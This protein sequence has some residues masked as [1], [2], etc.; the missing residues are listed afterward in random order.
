MESFGVDFLVGGPSRPS[1]GYH[2]HRIN[3]E[4]SASCET[5]MALSTR[6]APTG[7]NRT[8]GWARSRRSMDVPGDLRANYA[9][10]ST[11]DDGEEAPGRSYQDAFIRKA[12]WVARVGPRVALSAIRDETPRHLER[13]WSTSRRT[14][15]PFSGSEVFPLFLLNDRVQFLLPVPAAARCPRLTLGR[16]GIVLRAR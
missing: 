14:M 8:M 11:G 6:R 4:C 15:S 9:L 2:R 7:F 12:G 5:G 16:R 3:I 1:R 10:V 13:A